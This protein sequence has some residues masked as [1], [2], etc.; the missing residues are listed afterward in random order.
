MLYYGIIT[1]A[2]AMFSVQFYFKQLFQ[3][4]YGSDLQATFALSAYSGIAGLAALLIINGARFEYTHFTLFMSILK[5]LNGFGF[6]FCSLKAL[7]RIN[8]SLYSVFSMLGGMALPFA[9]GILFFGETLTPGKAICFV[10]ITAALLLTVEKGGQK[11]GFL[12]YAGI[13]VLNGMSGVLSK[14]FQ[15]APFEK[16][17]AAGFSLL[18]GLLSVIVAVVLFFIVR[19]EKRK[20]TLPMAVGAMGSGILGNVANWLLLIALVHLPASAQYPCVTGGVMILST[21]LC[22]FTPKKPG[23]RE[24]AS[25]ALS[26]AGLMVLMLF[27]R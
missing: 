27:E 4:D 8:L 3:K 11:S 15:A 10:L 20:L 1:A 21:A 14:I 22:Y 25:V 9:V 5:M 23:L 6:T 24:I 26:F 17:S 12:Y 7:G 13:F 18:S 2:V 19:K 16:T